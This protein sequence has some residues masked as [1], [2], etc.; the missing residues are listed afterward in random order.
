MNSPYALSQYRDIHIGLYSEINPA[1]SRKVS[2]E[3]QMQP[4]DAM[5]HLQRK[6]ENREAQ[7]KKSGCLN[8][9]RFGMR[10]LI[11]W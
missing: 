1:A 3:Y 4:C 7:I 2:Y 6:R 10:R 8:D 11:E 5:R 9:S